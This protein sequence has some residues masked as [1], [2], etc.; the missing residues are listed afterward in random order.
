MCWL[1][2]EYTT[3]RAGI[4][5]KMCKI[6]ACVILLLRVSHTS[7]RAVE[8]TVCLIYNHV[9]PLSLW[10]LM[11]PYQNPAGQNPACHYFVTKIKQVEIPLLSQSRYGHSP[12]CYNPA[13]AKF[14][15]LESGLNSLRTYTNDYST[16]SF[17]N[18]Y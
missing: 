3:Y 16:M 12:T 6:R 14:S 7:R 9:G 8:V 11:D 10:L 13:R 4:W 2:S 15:L 18:W 1:G 5:L 17:A